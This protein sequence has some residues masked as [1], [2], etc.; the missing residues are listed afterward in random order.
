MTIAIFNFKGG[1]LKTTS[2]QNIGASLAAKGKKV[3]IIDMDAQHNLSQ[4]FRIEPKISVYDSMSRKKALEPIEIKENL[5]IAANTLD[6]IKMEMELTNVM[7]EREYILQKCISKMEQTFDFVLIDCPPSLGLVTINAL[8]A[9]GEETK[10]LVPVETEF[11]GLKGFAVLDDALMNIDLKIWGAF[12]A[13]YDARKIIHQNVKEALR[14]Y[15]QDIVFNTAIRTNV[16]GAEAQSKG[17][18]IFDYAPNSNCAIDYNNLTNEILKRL[19][20]ENNG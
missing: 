15:K 6:M 16:A 7:R 20:N 1:N 9:G 19:K 14:E 12:A 4:V 8:L 3:L 11:L 2:T 10:I 13:K 5:Y 18:D 17:K